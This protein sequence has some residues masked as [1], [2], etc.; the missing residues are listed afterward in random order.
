MAPSSCVTA[1]A[2]VE[3][4]V[5]KMKVVA[6]VNGLHALKLTEKRESSDPIPTSSEVK[7]VSTSQPDDCVSTGNKHMMQCIDW[8]EH[9]FSGRDDDSSVPKL[10][11]TCI[12]P[13]QRQV[14]LELMKTKPG[15]TLTYKKLSERSV[16]Y[17]SAA[18]AVGTAM[19]DNPFI[20]LVPCHRV[21]PASSK[22]VEQVGKYAQGSDMKVRL[23]NFEKTFS[24]P[25]PSF[26]A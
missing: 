16:G 24:S 12:T 26:A 21:V 14:Y 4:I 7:C 6:C 13:F 8:L 17:G 15:E 10:C 3:T 19:K 5:G 23:I 25:K 20:L 1:T 11:L 22:G 9:Y 2:V 18:R